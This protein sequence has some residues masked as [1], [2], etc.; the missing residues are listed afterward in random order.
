MTAIR[1]LLTVVVAAALLG[2]SLPVVEDARVARTDAQLETTAVRV[3]ETATALATADDP[4]PLGERGAS[5]TLVVTL[6]SEG[7][8]DARADYLSIGGLPNDP[9]PTTVGYRVD[10]RAPEQV[11]AGVRLFTGERPL[12]L[13]PGRHTLRLVL[14]R[15]SAGVGVRISVVHSGV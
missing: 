8:A 11:D 14:V 15:T 3:S 6:S 7:F 5:R 2:A 1:T 13:S 4:V 9:H 12:V 10:G